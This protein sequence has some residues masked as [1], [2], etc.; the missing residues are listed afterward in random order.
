MMELIKGFLRIRVSPRYIYQAD[1]VV[2]TDHFRTAVQRVETLLPRCADIYQDSVFRMMSFV[3]RETAAKLHRSPI[4]LSPSITMKFNSV[5][6]KARFTFTVA[7]H[8]LM[9]I[10]RLWDCYSLI[11]F[12]TL[13]LIKVRDPGK[14]HMYTLLPR[15]PW[16]LYLQL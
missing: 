14:N 3:L 7:P 9:K 11:G 2:G 1:F 5:I 8:C 15:L 13:I 16:G 10:G 6:M 12:S 4:Q